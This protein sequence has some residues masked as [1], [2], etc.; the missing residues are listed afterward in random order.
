MP[1][2]NAFVS[3]VTSAALFSFRF[4]SRIS[5]PPVW[6]ASARVVASQ[7]RFS[8]SLMLGEILTPSS[9][10]QVWSALLPPMRRTGDWFW[11][12]SRISWTSTGLIAF[13]F[14]PV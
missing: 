5:L 11:L 14:G 13:G 10:H 7:L 9:G 1:V 12:T 3:A 2:R 6:T 8:V 4:R